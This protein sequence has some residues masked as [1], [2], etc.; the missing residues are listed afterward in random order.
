MTA[1]GFVDDTNILT[2]SRSTEANFRFL[3]R[4]NEKYM[5]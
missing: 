1:I 2:F 3:E 4:A 5:A